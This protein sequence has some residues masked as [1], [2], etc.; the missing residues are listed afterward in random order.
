MNTPFSAAG[1]CTCR[2]VRYQMMDQPMIVHCC[3]CYWCQRE[4]GSAFAVNAMIESDRVKLLCGEPEFVITPTNSGKGQRVA[5]C[6]HCRIAVWSHYS[7]LGEVVR[8]LRVGTLDEPWRLPPDVHIYT[9]SK[10]PWVQLPP[11]AR[12]F[13]QYYR[14]GEVWSAASLARRAAVTGRVPS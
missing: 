12:A 13:A 5:R 14:S 9:D 1:G 10:Q 2:T 7:G 6:P 4:T 8:F 3:H 11:G